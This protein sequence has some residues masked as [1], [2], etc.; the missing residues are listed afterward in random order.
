MK[1]KPL[2]LIVDDLSINRSVLKQIFNNDFSIIE[3]ENG[4]DALALLKINRRISIVLLDLYMPIMDGF[5]LIEAVRH[6]PALTHLPIVVATQNGEAE[7]EIRALK[8]GAD[9]FIT[10]PYYPEIIMHR[11]L[12]ILKRKNFDRRRIENDLQKAN[13]DIRKLVNRIPGGNDI[14]DEYEGKIYQIFDQLKHHGERDKLTGIY[15][16]ETFYVK[17]AE[18]LE[19]NR[20]EEYVLVTWNIEKFKIINEIFGIGTGDRILMGIATSF[21]EKL[22]GMGTYCRLEADHFAICFPKKYLDIDSIMA[23][24]DH[25]LLKY[26]LKYNII[27]CLGIYEIV[28]ISMPID[29]MCDRANLALNTIKGNY[30][31]RYAFYDDILRK[32][33]MEEQ[34][35]AGEMDEALEK[36]QFHVYMQPIYSTTTEQPVSAEALVRWIHPTKGIIP[37]DMFVPL[38]ERNGFI[39]KLD[40]YIWEEVCK[41]LRYLKDNNFRAFPISVNISRVDMYNPNICEEIFELTKKYEVNPSLFK[42]EITESAYMDNPRQLLASI[43]RFRQYGFSI[44]MDDFGSGYSSLNMLMNVP[45]DILKIDMSFVKELETSERACSVMHSVIRMAKWLEMIV[46]IM[47]QLSRQKSKTFIMN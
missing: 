32:R 6:D 45:V 23:S 47:A 38:F 17:T 1:K 3:A 34:Q 15:N 31:K 21:D 4:K 33:L 16:R 43:N 18:M 30:V 2:M 13:M 14:F 20:D 10:K 40:T 35:I 24:I 29:Q 25:G 44:L 9:D 11:I 39:I 5:Q 27:V 37:P 22:K 36:G 28:D 7:N 12:N 8:L 41:F 19:I 42:I 46:V 26:N